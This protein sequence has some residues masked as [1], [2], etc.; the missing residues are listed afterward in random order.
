LYFYTLVILIA[1][2][3]LGGQKEDKGMIC[4]IPSLFFLFSLIFFSHLPSLSHDNVLIS[5]T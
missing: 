4:S 3:I 1:T 2:S 5:W